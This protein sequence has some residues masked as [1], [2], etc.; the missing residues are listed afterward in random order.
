MRPSRSIGRRARLLAA[1]WRQ[2]GGAGRA[3]PPSRGSA[4]SPV[5]PWP[6]PCQQPDSQSTTRR[7]G[8]QKCAP[9][10]CA[11]VRTRINRVYGRTRRGLRSYPHPSHLKR[12]KKLICTPRVTR[13]VASCAKQQRKFCDFAALQSL[14]VW[15]RLCFRVGPAKSLLPDGCLQAHRPW[16]QIGARVTCAA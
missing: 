2:R 12:T 13:L 10:P 9:H 16:V 6:L 1:P 4:A 3:W 14:L 15:R 7:R 8:V 5:S 11:V